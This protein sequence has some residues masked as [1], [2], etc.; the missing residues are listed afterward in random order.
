MHADAPAPKKSADTPAVTG[1]VVKAVRQELPEVYEATGTVKAR[2]TT[3]LSARLMGHIREIRVQVGD[4]VSAG[5]VV[6]V[7]DARE[8]ETAVRQAEAARQEAQGA[9]P[10]VENAIAAAQAQLD[11]AKATYNRMKSLADQKSITPQEFDEASARLRMA[12]ANLKMAEAKRTQLQQ[13][14]RQADEGV[15]QVNIQKGYS[16]VTS[17]FAGIVLERKAEPGSLA[18]PGTPIVVVEQTGSYRLEAAVE[19]ARSAKCV[20]EPVP[21][22]SWMPSTRR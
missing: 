19:E 22:S 12:E 20:P 14:I 9:L 5:Q 11:L 16:Q 21:K 4:R 3:A 10:E 2:V 18:A 1:K 17:P 13:K 6:A 7:I 8:I 15:A